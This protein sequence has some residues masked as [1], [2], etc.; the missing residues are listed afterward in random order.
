LNLY[1]HVFVYYLFDVGNT[2]TSRIKT[3]VFFLDVT[4]FQTVDT[5]KTTGNDDRG[6]EE[7]RGTEQQTQRPPPSRSGVGGGEFFRFFVF[8]FFGFLFFWF[9]LPYL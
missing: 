2:R 5:E 7:G 1:E 4:A 8:C 3:N 6:G 9:V